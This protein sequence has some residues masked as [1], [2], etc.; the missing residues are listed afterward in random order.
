VQ[1]TGVPGTVRAASP[2]L[3]ADS[4][5]VLA[6]LGYSPAEIGHLRAGG[7]V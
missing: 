5:E 3:G 6:D 7:V 1:M 2:E 4:D